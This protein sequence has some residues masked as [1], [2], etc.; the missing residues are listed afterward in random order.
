MSKVIPIVVVLVIIAVVVAAFA[1]THA[2]PQKNSSDNM[3]MSNSSDMSNNTSSTNQTVTIE[4][5]T[6]NPANLTVKAG[7]TVVWINKDSN[8]KYMVTSNKTDLFMSDH[9]SNGQSFSYTFNQT[10][11]YDYYDMDHMDDNKLIGAIIV[12]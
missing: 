5:G 11:T 12:Q 8:S 2:N 6:F 10:G 7:T 9:L 3:N 1:I 4:N